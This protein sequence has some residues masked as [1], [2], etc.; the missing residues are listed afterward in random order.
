[1]RVAILFVALMLGAAAPARAWCEATCLSPTNT[2][3]DSAKPHCPVHEP[4]SDAPS[5]A[6]ANSPDCPVVESAR[7]V[8]AKIELKVPAHAIAS[9]PA[10]VR[11]SALSNAR[12]RAPLHVRTLASSSLFAP[13][14]I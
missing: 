6:A 5:M 10:R 2:R 13:L 4:S 9:H 1:M 12:T 11:T 3:G 14:R 7:P 8:I